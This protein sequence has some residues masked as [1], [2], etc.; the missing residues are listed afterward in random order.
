MRPEIH[1]HRSARTLGEAIEDCIQGGGPF[2][3]DPIGWEA[4]KNDSPQ[5]KISFYFKDSEQKYLQA[6]WGYNQ[7]TNVLFPVEF[8]NA[9]KFWVR[10][11]ENKR[12]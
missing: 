4:I 2:T 10:R 12:P 8:V 11:S 9:T 5:W 6:I 1:E 7:D 3:V